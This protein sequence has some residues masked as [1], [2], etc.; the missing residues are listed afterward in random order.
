MLLNLMH[1]L[2]IAV[3]ILAQDIRKRK[4]TNKQLIVI[5]FLA[6]RLTVLTALN[7][8]RCL[9]ANSENASCQRDKIKG[10]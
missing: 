6:N 3:V 2:N 4:T 8:D 1:I 9:P 5:M 7:P 10:R